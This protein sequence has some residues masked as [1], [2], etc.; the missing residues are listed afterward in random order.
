MT[1]KR[2]QE[3]IA[4][5]RQGK[6]GFS[7]VNK[8]KFHM[9]GRAICR[10]LAKM[11]GLE[12]GE[13]KISSNKAGP[14]VMGE[15]T[16]HTMGVYFQL[17]GDSFNGRILFRSCVGLKDYSGG[18]NQ[19]MPFEELLD[20]ERVAKKLADIHNRFEREENARIN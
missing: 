14:A 5:C 17:Q 10:E 2:L 20:L 15:V 1:E 3:F 4:I 19:W 7:E 9:T 8:R 6:H 16:L 11:M 18:Q 13:Y 12:I